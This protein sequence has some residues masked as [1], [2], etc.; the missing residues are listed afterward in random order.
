MCQLTVSLEGEDIVLPSPS[1]R[2][3][4]F[5]T[6]ALKRREVWESNEARFACLA[7]YSI[8]GFGLDARGWATEFRFLNGRYVTEGA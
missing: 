7:K 1:N 4:C 3:R 8:D 2:A 5:P 6:V